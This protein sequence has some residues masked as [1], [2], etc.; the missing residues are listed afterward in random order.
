MITDLVRRISN[1]LTQNLK[2]K[3]LTVCQ[4]LFDE[5]NDSLDRSLLAVH[6]E[7]VTQPSL[8]FSNYQLVFQS[9]PF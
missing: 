2:S 7:R 1:T 3:R 9:V 6:S 8:V 4:W 5:A